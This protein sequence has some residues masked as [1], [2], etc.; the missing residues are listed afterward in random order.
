MAVKL[1]AQE[2]YHAIYA[3]SMQGRITHIT[4]ALGSYF[5][6]L[7]YDKLTGVPL[8]LAAAAAAGLDL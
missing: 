4:T 3:P 6:C 8:W 1:H 7:A 5:A 2:G